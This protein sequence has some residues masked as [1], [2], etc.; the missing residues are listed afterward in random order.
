MKSYKSLLDTKFVFVFD[1]IL[2]CNFNFKKFS[3][4][5]SGT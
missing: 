1:V 2:Y 3:G 5:P 4:E